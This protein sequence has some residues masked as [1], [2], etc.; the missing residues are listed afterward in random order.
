MVL[1][2]FTNR[3]VYEEAFVPSEFGKN[4]F[5]RRSVEAARKR[6]CEGD[7]CRCWGESVK[8]KGKLQ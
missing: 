8:I 5:L 6:R 2:S 4:F 1:A 3:S 7:S